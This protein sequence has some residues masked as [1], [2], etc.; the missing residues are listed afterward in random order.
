LDPSVALLLAALALVAGL[1]TGWIVAQ[2]RGAQRAGEAEAA[3]Q[4]AELALA[5][6]SAELESERRVAA[7]R[8]ALLEQARKQVEDAVGNLARK[9]L[10]ENSEQFLRQANEKFAALDQKAQGELDK[11]KREIEGLLKP[12]AENLGKLETNAKLMEEKRA[13][14][15]GSLETHLLKLMT[16]TDNLQKS[17][18]SLATALRGSSQARGRWGE[19]ALKNVAEL[20]GMTEH[21]DFE[22]QSMAEGLRPDMVVRLP[23]EDRI[24]VDAKVPLTKFLE[25]M[26]GDLPPEQRTALLVEHAAALKAH[27]NAL[28][29][30]DYAD[31][32]GGR[33]DFTVL[34]VPADPILSAAFEHAPELQADA[35]RRKV[36]IATPVTLV[37]LLRT[38]ATYWR[39]ASIERNAVDVR[40]AARELYDRVALFAEHLGN[41]GRG[42]EKALQSYND[43][44]GSFQTRVLPSGQKLDRLEV[45]DGAKRK[46]DGVDEVE[47]TPRRLEKGAGT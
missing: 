24:P 26:E 31:L 33:V 16:T 9:A 45:S 2:R 7:S 35:M 15:Y 6:R 36:L 11:R 25:A 19:L 22:L 8:E 17:S 5:T 46:L 21:C 28:A 18:S 14:A 34:F 20:A 43:A 39:Q 1:L 42:L 44:A 40:D 10:N 30:K 47:G 23:G 38:V 32:L 4:Q 29:Q 12:L 13:Q 37:A 41:V 27:V 3:R